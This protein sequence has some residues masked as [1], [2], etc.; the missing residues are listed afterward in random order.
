MLLAFQLVFSFYREDL[1]EAD[2]EHP[3]PG[4]FHVDEEERVGL[5]VHGLL[6]KLHQHLNAMK[7]QRKQQR[8]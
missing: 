6:L 5:I 3:L 2:G 1:V 8:V 7:P 4:R